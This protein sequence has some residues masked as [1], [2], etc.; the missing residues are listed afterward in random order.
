MVVIGPTIYDPWYY[1]DYYYSM[2]WYWRVWHRPYYTA[3]GGWAISWVAIAVG[4]LG[5]WILLGVLSSILAKR[6]RNR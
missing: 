1:H 2:P 5:V 4:L 6:R 3:S